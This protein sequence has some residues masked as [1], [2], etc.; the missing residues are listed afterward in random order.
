MLLRGKEQIAEYVQDSLD[1]LQC[2]V[3]QLK[4]SNLE[5]LQKT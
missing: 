4:E 1:Q 2:Q 3:D 5:I